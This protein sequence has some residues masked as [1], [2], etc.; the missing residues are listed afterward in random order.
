MRALIG[1]T[2]FVGSNLKEQVLFDR[3]YN[4]KNIEDIG[5][6]EFDTI[7]CAG[8]SS[9]KWRANK[10]PIEDF[11]QIERLISNL[12]KAKF[13][14]LVLVSTIA[15]YDNPADNPYGQNRLYLETY[16]KNRFDNIYI[17]RLPSL[18]GKHLRKNAIYDLLNG[19]TRFL[20]HRNSKLQYYCLDDLWKDI[21]KMIE[22]DIRILN[23][24]TEPVVFSEIL[25]I[26]GAVYGCD[27]SEKL[28]EENMQSTNG[29][30]WDKEG[31]Y[32]YDKNEILDR[33]ER[34]IKNE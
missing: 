22:N 18:F 30:V 13:R 28:V 9:V 6:E 14:R 4:S 33:L 23:I 19:D 12:E 7:V 32:L 1:H 20:P 8:V 29:F 17:V 5:G 27:N 25:K 31:P 3:F 24:S 21:S 2:G 15:V 10:Q 11:R 34:F 26:F 16:L